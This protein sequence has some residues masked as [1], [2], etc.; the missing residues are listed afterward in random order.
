MLLV[1]CAHAV[2]QT[3]HGVAPRMHL[4]V[5]P[6]TRQEWCHRRDVASPPSLRRVQICLVLPVLTNPA[7]RRR[8]RL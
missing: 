3:F 6:A 5:D 4:V 2:T 7:F 1:G 8:L